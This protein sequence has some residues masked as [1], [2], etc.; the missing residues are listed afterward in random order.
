[1]GYSTIYMKMSQIPSIGILNKQE[2]LFSKMEIRKVRRDLSGGW[3]HQWEGEDIRRGA[4]GWIW[5]KCYVLMYENGKMR[6]VETV[7]GM[8]VRGIKEWNLT[9][10]FCK[11]FCKC[12]TVPPVQQ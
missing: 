10:I 11:N 2:C 12:H 1:L 8:G 3:R 5:W 9:M 6:P 7:P 4:G